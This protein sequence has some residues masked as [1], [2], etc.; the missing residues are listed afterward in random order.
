VAVKVRLVPAQAVVA[1]VAIETFTESPGLTVTG[2]STTVPEQL[3]ISGVI[4]YVTTPVLKA[5]NERLVDHP[6]ESAEKPV[7]LP[8]VRVAVQ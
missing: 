7:T 1:V 5:V 3:P 6:P 8:D 4:W 2:K